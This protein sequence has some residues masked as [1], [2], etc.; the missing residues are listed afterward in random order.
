MNQQGLESIGEVR[1]ETSTSSAK[2]NTPVNVTVS[3]G[4]TEISGKDSAAA[5][6][7]RADKALYQA[8][9]AGRNACIAA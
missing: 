1:V 4:V 5:A 6:I 2:F 9:D 8:K 3:C 7:E